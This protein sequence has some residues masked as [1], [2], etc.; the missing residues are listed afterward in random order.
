METVQLVLEN[1]N[2]NNQEIKKRGL[3]KTRSAL[4]APTPPP[5]PTQ[6]QRNKAKSGTVMG[7]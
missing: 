2:N 7:E 6:V 3:K 1:K 4:E 5:T